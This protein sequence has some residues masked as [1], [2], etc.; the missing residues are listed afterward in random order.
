MSD[1]LNQKQQSCLHC[2]I[3]FEKLLSSENACIPSAEPLLWMLMPHLRTIQ[4]YVNKETNSRIKVN[5]EQPTVLP[6]YQPTQRWNWFGEKVAKYCSNVS[7][8]LWTLD[9]GKGISCWLDV[10]P[11]KMVATNKFTQFW[12][13]CCERL[14][15]WFGEKTACSKWLTTI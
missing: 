10:I 8:F 12:I 5:V 14:P 15:S 13:L 3:T 1:S 6:T 11:I 2:R 9:L 7:V 4:N